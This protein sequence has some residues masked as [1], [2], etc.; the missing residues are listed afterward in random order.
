MTVRVESIQVDEYFNLAD[1]PSSDVVCLMLG[2]GQMPTAFDENGPIV[3]AF[4]RLFNPSLRL[5]ARRLG[6][7]IRCDRLSTRGSARRDDRT[8]SRHDD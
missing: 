5:L 3:E 8:N 4:G 2:I 1:D 6:S 7:R